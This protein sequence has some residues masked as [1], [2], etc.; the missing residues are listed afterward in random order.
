MRSPTAKSVVD[1]GIAK[2]LQEYARGKG[3]GPFVSHEAF[4]ASLHKES[5]RL[6]A[7]KKK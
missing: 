5:R 4:I 1:R 2:S 3:F 6:R 7:K